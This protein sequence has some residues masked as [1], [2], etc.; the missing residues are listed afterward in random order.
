MAKGSG[1]REQEARL[2]S[3]LGT[4]YMKMGELELASGYFES[5]I[6]MFQEVGDLRGEAVT[7]L[8][9]GRAHALGMELARALRV[10]LECV[11]MTRDEDD[12]S[13]FSEANYRIG[14]LYNFVEDTGSALRFYSDAAIGYCREGDMDLSLRIVSDMSGVNG[15]EEDVLRTIERMIRIL[16]GSRWAYIKHRLGW[17]PQSKDSDIALLKVLS[18][19]LEGKEVPSKMIRSSIPEIEK[20][21]MDLIRKVLLREG[22]PNRRAARKVLDGL[23]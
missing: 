7:M 9:S 5:A 21:R 4:A 18:R 11:R 19:S 6:T 13:I 3:N 20:V 8:N 17:E 12:L 15:C 16:T 2:L 10:Y 14:H 22:A 23:S 1:S